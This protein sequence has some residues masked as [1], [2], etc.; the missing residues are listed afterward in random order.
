MCIYEFLRPGIIHKV[1]IMSIEVNV[2]LPK[3]HILTLREY[4]SPDSFVI[5][6][7]IEVIYQLLEV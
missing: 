1:A 3:V 5:A 2:P 6:K 7:S 4:I